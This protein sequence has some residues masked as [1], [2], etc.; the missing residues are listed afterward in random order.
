LTFRFWVT[1]KSFENQILWAVCQLIPAGNLMHYCMS[2]ESLDI[3]QLHY[4]DD[5][6]P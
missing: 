3:G 1:A 6:L 4:D 2:C 5:L